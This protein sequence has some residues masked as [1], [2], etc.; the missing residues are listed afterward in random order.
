M[1]ALACAIMPAGA[2]AQDLVMRR[3]LPKDAQPGSTTPTPGPEET[4]TPGGTP[5]PTPNP[6]ATPTPTPVETSTPS[7]VA[8]GTNLPNL[9]KAQWVPTVW[10]RSTPAANSCQSQTMEYA[11]QADYACKDAS[12]K[13]VDTLR[14]WDADGTCEN[15]D[16]DMDPDVAP[17]DGLDYP[18]NG[19]AA[20]K[21][22]WIWTRAVKM[23]KQPYQSSQRGTHPLGYDV[24]TGLDAVDP[25]RVYFDS[26]YVDNIPGKFEYRDYMR[27]GLNGYDTG[28]KLC[29]EVKN[30][31]GT[32]CSTYG[33]DGMW[34][35]V[36]K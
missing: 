35:G 36:V 8:C 33:S 17:V 26:Y 28:G 16:G 9:I 19:D 10:G 5:S 32:V 24:Y 3:P 14:V 23:S 12:G 21:V 1:A 6:S 11:C 22:A 34:I 30:Q 31:T 4:P 27:V 7:E 13:T 15:Y 2:V 25:K 29:Q 20:Q 18:A